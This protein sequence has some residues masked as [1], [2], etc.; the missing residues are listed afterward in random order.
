MNETEQGPRPDFNPEEVAAIMTGI[1]HGLLQDFLSRQER[2]VSGNSDVMG[3]GQ[4]FLDLT[5]SL[6]KNPQRVR[7]D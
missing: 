3:I 5:A 4:S 7:P 1:A 2:A 6:M